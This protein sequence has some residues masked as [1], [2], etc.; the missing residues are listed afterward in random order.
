MLDRRVVYILLLSFVVIVFAAAYASS[1]PD[2]LEWVAEQMGF[3]D[4][5]SEDIIKAPMSDYE[6][7][8]VKSSYLSTLL[9]GLVGAGIAGAVFFIAGIFFSKKSS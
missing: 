9:A 7:P 4:N 6:T 2:G 8:F 1:Y 5:V 3:I